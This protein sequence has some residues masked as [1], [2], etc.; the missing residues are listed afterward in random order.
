MSV[1]SFLWVIAW[2]VVSAAI[3]VVIFTKLFPQVERYRRHRNIVLAALYEAA[4]TIS[5]GILLALYAF[6]QAE[7]DGLLKFI[8]YYWLGL[9]VISLAALL[10]A[11]KFNCGNVSR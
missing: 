9:G 11:S 8:G 4:H 5:M 7:P 10:I 6:I 3:N 2:L 1:S